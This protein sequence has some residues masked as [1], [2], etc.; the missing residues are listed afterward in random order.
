[1]TMQHCESAAPS[2]NLSLAR[3]IA[4]AV[5]GAGKP[6]HQI[7]SEAGMH[8]VTLIRVMRGERPIGLDEAERILSVCGVFSRAAMI[9][10]LIG[11]EA[12]AKEWM[13]SEAGEFLEE[14]FVTLPSQLERTLGRKLADLR[15]RWAN[16]TSQM[17]ARTLAK[18]IDEFANRDFAM[19]AGR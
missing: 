14:L 6:R 10:A 17:V 9:L 5:E 15:P 11:E 2:Y 12:L 19:S 4:H 13:R 3:T 16:G 1:M 7:A 8:R 18:H